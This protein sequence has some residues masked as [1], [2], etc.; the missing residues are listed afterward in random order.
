[1]KRGEGEEGRQRREEAEAAAE[2]EAEARL[3]ERLAHQLSQQWSQVREARRQEEPVIETGPSNFS[4]AQVPWAYDLA[5]AWAWRFIVIAVALLMVLWTIKFFVV[6]FFPLVI[7]L[8]IAALTAPLVALM[9]RA[10]IPR[11]LAAFLVVA[12]GIAVVALLLT[13]VGQQ[14]A[15][16]ADQL[17]EKVSG[18]LGEIKDWLQTGP[19]HASDSQINTWIS[20]AQDYVQKQGKD[21]GSNA[22][23]VGAALGHIV[24]GLFI[25]LFATYF[26]LADGQKIWAWVVRIFPRAARSRADSSGRVAW[27]SLTQFVRATVLVAG[28]DAVGIMIV[29]LILDVPLVSAIGVLVFLGAF[30]PLVGAFLSGTVAVLV[31]LVAQ[32]PLAA[33]LMLGGV[34]L[35]Q[36]IEAHVLQPFLMGRFVSVHPLG[37]ILA[38]AMGAIVAGIVGALVAVPL[39]AA[40]NAVVQHLAAYVEMEEAEESDTDEPPDDPAPADGEPAGAAPEGAEE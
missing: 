27:R 17:S 16:S 18:G 25:I 35:V 38:I 1:M 13:F 21:L 34:V 2:Q 14:I 9:E 20:D 37:V 19:L 39:A 8:F 36:Q 28:T 10:H 4:R 24:A 3:R 15:S 12:G 32:G 22:T 11:K 30:I 5:A 33:A 29:A 26:F 6:V 40:L 31:A 23:E 7:A